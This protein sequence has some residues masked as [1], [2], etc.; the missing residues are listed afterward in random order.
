MGNGTII[1]VN[2]TRA[3]KDSPEALRKISRVYV[4]LTGSDEVYEGSPSMIYMATNLDEK[5]IKNFALKTPW[6]SKADK[7]KAERLRIQAEK[8]AEREALRMEKSKR[9]EKLAL[10]KLRKIEKLKATTKKGVKPRPQDDEDQEDQGEEENNNIELYPVVY[11]GFLALEAVVE[12]DDIDLDAYK[13]RKFGDYAYLS[14]KDY[15]TFTAVLAYLDKKFALSP[16]TKKRLDVLHDTFQTGRGRKFAVEQVPMTQ[17]KNFYV[18]NHKLSAKDKTTGKPELKVY[19]VI[20]N[21]S[22]I[23]N[24]DIATNPAIR[25]VLNKSIAVKAG[26]VSKTV[27]FQKASGIDV[28]FFN[29]K[30]DLLAKFKALKAEGFEITNEDEFLEDLNKLTLKKSTT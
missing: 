2:Q 25:T 14:V 17:L 10:E 16:L 30:K 5:S 11:N 27:K 9:K 4:K 26:A 18:L 15:P 7:A 1:K 29:S 12:D 13:F 3:I 23:L 6:A 21:G 28:Q 24:V 20:L 8:N 22:L 19:P